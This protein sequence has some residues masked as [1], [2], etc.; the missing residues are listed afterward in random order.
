MQKAKDAMKK[1]NSL[2][3][4]IA[5]K[6]ELL[7]AIQKNLDT[8]R[9]EL[10]YAIKLW[11]RAQADYD[12]HMANHIHQE[13]TRHMERHVEEM[14][15]QLTLQMGEDSNGAFQLALNQ[16]LEEQQLQASKPQPI[17]R[18]TRSIPVQPQLS[19][20]KVP[21]ATTLATVEPI[22][23]DGDSTDNRGSV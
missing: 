6:R 2:E 15:K 10:E 11:T 8:T 22:E 20:I 17:V 3:L 1:A 13:S 9:G 19:D 23:Q 5:Q 16:H 21:E 14:N 18:P 12:S 7:T 4:I